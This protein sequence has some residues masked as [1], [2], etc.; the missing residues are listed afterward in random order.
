M[1]HLYVGRSSAVRFVSGTV[2]LWDVFCVFET[3]RV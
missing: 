2:Y 3:F 1:E